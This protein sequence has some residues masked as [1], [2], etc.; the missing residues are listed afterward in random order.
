MTMPSVKYDVVIVGAGPAGITAAIALA[1]AN[2]P[3]LV[4]E[5]GVIRVPGDVEF[6]FNFG[7]PPRTAYACMSETI[8]LALEGRIENFTL[9]KDVSVE[10]VDQINLLAAK[11]GFELAKF[12][13]FEK[14]VDDAAIGRARD[15]RRKVRAA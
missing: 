4:I 14:A 12:R 10:Q 13:S 6:N 11:H 8:M 3:V 9:G 7:F 5:G 1:K 2:I 15:A